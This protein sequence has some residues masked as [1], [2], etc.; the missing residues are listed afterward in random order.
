MTAISITAG[1]MRRRPARMWIAAAFVAAIS[2]WPA[3]HAQPQ[4]VAHSRPVVTE[5]VDGPAVSFVIRFGELI[6]H[7]RAR[8]TLVMPGRTRMLRARLDSRPNTLFTA[9]GALP[10]G[11]YQLQWEVIEADSAVSRGAIHFVVT[12][13]D[14]AHGRDRVAVCVQTMTDGNIP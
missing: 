13:A 4:D 11:S 1:R 2:W 3:A 10:P 9:A 7:E 6:D 12:I 5:V 8:V 14:D